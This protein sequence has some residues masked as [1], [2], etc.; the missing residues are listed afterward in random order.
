ADEVANAIVVQRGGDVVGRVSLTRQ[1]RF[2]TD[3]EP[4]RR[5]LFVRVDADIEHQFEVTDEDRS[6]YDR[7]YHST[8]KATSRC[9]PI[10]CWPPSSVKVEPLSDLVSQM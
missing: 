5:E 10:R 9:N 4:L 3:D 2:D 8:T 1:R 7:H 6:F